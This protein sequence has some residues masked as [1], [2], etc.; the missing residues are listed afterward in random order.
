MLTGVRIF[1]IGAWLRRAIA[2]VVPPTTRKRFFLRSF[3]QVSRMSFRSVSVFRSCLVVLV[4]TGAISSSVAARAEGLSRYGLRSLRPVS[5]V[6]GSQVRGQGFSAGVSGMS[7]VTGFLIDPSSGSNTFAVST[8]NSVNTSTG[9]GSGTPVTQETL[10]VLQFGLEVDANGSL[11][12]GAVIGQAGGGSAAAFPF[13]TPVF[14]PP[15]FRF[16]R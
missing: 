1:A 8:S 10:S 3:S 15:S 2:L 12:S 16:G 4:A 14:S 6:Q 5:D 7:F 13:P 11:F 9:E